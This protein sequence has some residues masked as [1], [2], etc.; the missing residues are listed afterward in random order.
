MNLITSGR[1]KRYIFYAIG[2]ILLVVI[3]IFLA[4]QLNNWNQ[5]RI[6]SKNEKHILLGLKQEFEAARDELKADM[7]ARDFI[8]LT[9]ENL[10]SL[11]HEGSSLGIPSDSVSGF[12]NRFFSYRFYTT[13]HPV[14]DDLQSSG[15]MNLIKSEEVRYA[16][17]EYIREKNRY[18]ITEERERIF[19]RTELIPFFSDYLD[20]SLVYSNQITS[21]DIDN[22]LKSVNERTKMGSILHQRIRYTER[23][24]E[25]G[26]LVDDAIENVLFE[27]E[28]H[29]P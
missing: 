11:H 8:I 16:I 17:S 2:E 15:R 26:R 5:D 21:E 25:Y 12:F 7:R 3:G 9:S 24:I 19:V 18:W 14:L 6:N 27:I 13:A 20:L 28:N 4:I 23:A 29:I 1:L 22:V 10:L